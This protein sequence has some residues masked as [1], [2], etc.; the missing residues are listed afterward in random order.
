MT[1]IPVPPSILLIT[2]DCL[3]ADHVGCL[4][5]GRDITPAIDRLARESLVFS[6]ALVAG[7]PTYNSFAALL[8]GR[9]PLA[10]G[11]DVVG[12]A[13]GETTLASHL[14]DLGYRTGA[15]IAGNPYASRWMGYDQGFAYLEDFLKSATSSGVS[16]SAPGHAEEHISRWRG[17][18]R[19]IQSLTGC[20]AILQT[21]YQELYFAYGLWAVGRRHRGDYDA[22]LNKHPRAGALTAEAI[23]WLASGSEPFFLW[24]HYMDAHRPYYP[25][26]EALKK[27]GRT[28]LSPKKMFKLR[29]IWLRNDLSAKRL[30]RHREDFLALYDACIFAI[31]SQLGRLL[32]TLG[33]RGCLDHTIVVLTADHGEAFLEHG[34][35]DHHPALAT[36]ELINVPLFIRLPGGRQAARQV[37]LPFSHIDLLPTILDMAG[38][39]CPSAFAG[40]SRWP[41]LKDGRPWHDPAITEMVYGH[42]LSPKGRFTLPGFRLLAATGERYKLV[43][44]FA[45]GSEELFDLDRDPQEQH[46]LSPSANPAAAHKLLSALQRHLDKSLHNRHSRPELRMRLGKI[47]QLISEPAS[48]EKMD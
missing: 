25:P 22:L 23:N 28:D 4:G 6:R 47:R 14:Q 29:N 46:G 48:I 36:H 42:D 15:I 7:S 10:L 26:E 8:A 41:A 17:L 18:N 21:I 16:A 39:S 32:D 11:R 40:Q 9:Y 37:A 1:G 31:D 27:L 2:I 12:L 20:S 5:Y 24:V 3:R 30:L 38:L 19:A 35:R 44:N 43:I 45:K 33:D 13:P 34:E